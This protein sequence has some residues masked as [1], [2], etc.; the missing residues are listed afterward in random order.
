MINLNTIARYKSLLELRL[1]AQERAFVVGMVGK[2]KC[3]ITQTNQRHAILGRLV[4]KGILV[5][6]DRSQYDFK[7]P[8]LVEHIEYRCLRNCKELL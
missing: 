8:E 1:S 4:K 5:K 6:T 7:D 2:W 3:H